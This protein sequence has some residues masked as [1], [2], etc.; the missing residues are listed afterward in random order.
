MSQLEMTPPGPAAQADDGRRGSNL[1]LVNP[2]D[3][4]VTRDDG[5]VPTGRGSAVRHRAGEHRI[6]RMI[7]VRPKPRAVELIKFNRW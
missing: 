5:A 3:V 7:V 6:R 4:E 1:A 2:R